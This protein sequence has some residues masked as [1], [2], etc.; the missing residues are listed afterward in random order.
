[1]KKYNIRTKDCN[2]TNFVCDEYVITDRLIIFRKDYTDVLIVS[3]YNLEY[4]E[5]VE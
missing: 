3:V 4:L 2:F 5:L 1:M